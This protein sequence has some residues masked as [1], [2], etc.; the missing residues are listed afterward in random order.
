[1]YDELYSRI[2]AGCVRDTVTGCLIWQGGTDGNAER[3]YGRISYRGNKI[4]THIGVYRAKKGRVPKGKEVDHRC[5]VSLCC[6]IEHLQAVTPLKNQ[7]L[8]QKRM[9]HKGDV[10][11]CLA[12]K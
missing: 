9:K 5:V 6:E 1:M 7:R 11:K 12:V 4:A 10:L 2:V 8:K 3:P